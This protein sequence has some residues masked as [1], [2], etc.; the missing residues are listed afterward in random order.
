[1][2]LL[3][4]IKY[5]F[6]HILST[7]ILLFLSC[8]PNFPLVWHALQIFGACFCSFLLLWQA[9]RMMSAP[10]YHLQLGVMAIVVPNNSSLL[11][12]T[13]TTLA[14]Q[15]STRLS[16]FYWLAWE[17]RG[18]WPQFLVKILI[19]LMT[20]SKSQTGYWYFMILHEE[21][22]DY[23]Q[24]YSSWDLW[25]DA[26]WYKPEA[27]TR[28]SDMTSPNQHGVCRCKTRDNVDACERT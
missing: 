6:L 8:C 4:V 12:Q 21:G 19:E 26:L 25:Y 9:W 18:P 24:F 11:P 15:I 27:Q 2:F 13:C 28:C 22:K 3:P 14:W 5:L 20:C 1:M 16:K 17:D 7:I 23:L 10:P